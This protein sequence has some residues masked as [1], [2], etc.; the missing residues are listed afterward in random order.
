MSSVG[1]H[2]EVKYVSESFSYDANSRVVQSSTTH[3]MHHL[4]FDADLVFYSNIGCM[5]S[6]YPIEHD[7]ISNSE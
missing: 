5:Q 4:L 2:C 1:Q 7:W 3:Y 6:N